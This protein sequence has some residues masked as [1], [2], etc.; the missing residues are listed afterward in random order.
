MAVMATQRSRL[1][2]VLSACLLS[3]RRA[4][5]GSAGSSKSSP[6]QRN[7]RIKCATR[8]RVY[9]IRTN[10]GKHLG[11]SVRLL[12]HAYKPNSS[13]EEAIVTRRF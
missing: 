7:E 12:Y 10:A 3:G 13:F 5:T 8:E 2:S 11:K 9:T 1:R 4:G 6:S